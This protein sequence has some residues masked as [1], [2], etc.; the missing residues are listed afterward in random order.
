MG[1]AEPIASDGGLSH[2]TVMALVAMAVA[3]FVVANDFTAL[4]VALPQIE[5]DF[6]V[7]LTTAQWVINGYALVF[8]VLIVSG[9]RL[10]DMLGR[11]RVFFVGAGVFAVFSVI[12]GAAPDIE[13]LLFARA[14]MG[15]GGAL[16]WPAILGMTF[17]ILPADKAGLAGGSDSRLGGARERR[18]ATPWWTAHGCRRLA[19]DLL[20]ERSGGG[21]RGVCHLAKRASLRDPQ[22][23]QPV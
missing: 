22:P 20:S 6:D 5:K 12:G 4:S 1:E 8:G 10:A 14:V 21:L 7:D 9:G 3:V 17:A 2:K 19:L 11:R 18:G 13:V 23:R 16:M 15:I